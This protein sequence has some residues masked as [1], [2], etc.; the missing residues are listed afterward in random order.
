MSDS[1]QRLRAMVIGVSPERALMIQ[2]SLQAHGHEVVASLMDRADLHGQ[3][4]SL[5]PDVL[6]VDVDSPDSDTLEAMQ[7]IDRD[8]PR[9]I[10]MFSNDGESHMIEAAVHAGISAYVVDGLRAG[11]VIPIVEVA[12][13]RF[14]E[15]Q[16]LRR[17][18]AEARNALAERKTI[19]RAKGI[20]M[21]QRRLEEDA[22]YAAMR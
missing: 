10:V 21:K 1:A 2:R 22:A 19:E 17:A 16:T 20:L 9:P 15:H 18:L 12:M 6:I 3:L 8:H 7:A 5:Q 14:K 4:V 13:A 11:R